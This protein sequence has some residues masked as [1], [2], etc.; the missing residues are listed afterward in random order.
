MGTV[1]SAIDNTD[2]KVREEAA[3][4]ANTELE[5][6]QSF[7][8]KETNREDE[9]VKG[10]C[11]IKPDPDADFDMEDSSSKKDDDGLSDL[12]LSEEEFD[13]TD[14]D[15]DGSSSKD[16]GRKRANLVSE[17]TPAKAA[18]KSVGTCNKCDVRHK[19]GDRC[20]FKP[21]KSIDPTPPRSVGW[22]NGIRGR[23]G[24]VK[25]S[26]QEFAQREREREGVRERVRTLPPSLYNLPLHEGGDQHQHPSEGYEDRRRSRSPR[27]RRAPSPLPSFQF[28]TARS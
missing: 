14:R 7:L 18:A 12:S 10:R 17:K 19:V 2:C 11:A 15:D 8:M 26:N 28:H 22:F 27:G 5:L 13:K 3:T 25:H 23:G 6:S 9:K 20:V 16:S 24:R 1:E 21:S 4:T